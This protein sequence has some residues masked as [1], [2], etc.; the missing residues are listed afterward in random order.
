MPDGYPAA[1]NA[2]AKQGNALGITFHS[3]SGD[4][5][6]NWDGCNGVSVGTPVDIPHNVGIGGTTLGVD[7]NGHETSEVAWGGSGGGV[8]VLFGVP[9]YQKHVPTIVN[10]GRN[11]P[12]LAFDADP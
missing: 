11:L 4:G 5:G 1:L 2:V 7:V 3:A 9:G 8:S 10:T 6:S 12:D